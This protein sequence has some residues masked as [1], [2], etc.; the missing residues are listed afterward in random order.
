MLNRQRDLPDEELY[1]K[2]CQTSFSEF[3]ERG[4]MS[5]D[6]YE[7]DSRLIEQLN[8]RSGDVFVDT[9]NNNFL[10]V[11]NTFCRVVE[12]VR[13]EG[14]IYNQD[15]L[16]G[17]IV[18]PYD[19]SIFK[20]LMG[21]KEI[22]IKHTQFR[23]GN[24]AATGNIVDIYRDVPDFGNYVCMID[25]HL[26]DPST[27]FLEKDNQGLYLECFRFPTISRFHKNELCRHMLNIE[28][29]DEDE[30]LQILKKEI[31]RAQAVA[32]RYILNYPQVTTLP[33]FLDGAIG[34]INVKIWTDEFDKSV[35][36]LL[37]NKLKNIEKQIETLGISYLHIDNR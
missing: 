11:C 24:K 13:S 31:V 9:E 5:I 18:Q 6:N 7:D 8:L 14:S 3:L 37:E 2:K 19:F 17:K 16:K 15:T 36:G 10:A 23:Y 30:I 35:R 29:K 25:N 26:I 32:L 27:W 33:Y 21:N 20:P 34:S 12:Y 1:R 22:I 4:F 28:G